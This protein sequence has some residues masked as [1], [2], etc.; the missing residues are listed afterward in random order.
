METG[1]DITTVRIPIVYGP[2]VK[3][4]FL[5]LMELVH[6]GIP[7]PLQYVDNRRS[8]IYLGNLVDAIIHS[9]NHPNASGK[10]YLVSDG[11]EVST[12]ELIRR[13][14]VA[15]GKSARLI[16]FP[17]FLMR[18]AGKL[19]GKSSSVE[20]LLGSLSVDSSTIRQELGWRPPYTM[21]QGLKETADWYL[22]SSKKLKS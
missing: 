14:A 9:I 2:G 3:A 15:L 20:R 12:P 18:L 19:I 4:N 13:V 8:L 5:R 1:L 7:I 22:T 21:V 6:R 16:P 17:L 11:E 10:T